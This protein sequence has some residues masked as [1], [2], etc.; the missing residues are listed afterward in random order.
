MSQREQFE[1]MFRAVRAPM[2]T[3]ATPVKKTAV[4]Q[5]SSPAA[6]TS[7]TSDTDIKWQK[8]PTALHGYKEAQAALYRLLRP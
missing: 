8:K 1:K 6:E 3:G 4:K 5:Q 7:P 2:V